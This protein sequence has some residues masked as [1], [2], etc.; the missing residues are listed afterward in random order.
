MKE[1]K[2]STTSDG[3]GSDPNVVLDLLP[4]GARVLALG[5]AAARLLDGRG[6]FSV[7]HAA[8]D[9]LDKLGEE[10]FEVVVLVDALE[11]VPDP[12]ALLNRVRELLVTDGAVVASLPNA[13]HGSVR[14]ALLAGRFDQREGG[15]LDG[16]RR[17]FT[18]EAI[19]DL[20]E[21]SGYVITHWARERFDYSDGG[22]P[23]EEAIREVLAADPES[24]TYRFAV[25]AVPSDGAT[26]LAAAHEELRSVRTELESLRA[27][28]KDVDGLKEELEALRRAY[29]ERGR[30]VVAE[31]LEFANELG[32]LQR[33][34]DALHRSRSFR[35]T[36]PLR[37]FLGIFRGR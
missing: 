25:R 3:A 28:A 8:A 21:E 13:A 31:R 23:G 30:R 15:P 26:Q 20:F 2:T 34:L 18:R 10:Q 6:D 37:R 11:R 14:L 22:P 27:A 36:A 5:D 4:R 12:R 1:G 32:E 29:E 16:Q 7:T 33:H 17:F 24:T 9:G 19:S 35:Y